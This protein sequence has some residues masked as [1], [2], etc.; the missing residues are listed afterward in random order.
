MKTKYLVRKRQLG[1]VLWIE[2]II[3]KLAVKYKKI[4]VYTKFLELF[5]NY[6]V[7]NVV[8]KKDLNLAE[9]IFCK[10]EYYL[11]TKLLFIN[12][13]GAYE[14]KPK[15]HFLHAYQR[16]TG[17]S[18]TNEYPRLYLSEKEKNI[19]LIKAPKY[20]VLH[21][22]SFANRN[23]RKVYG[24]NW[25]EI[26]AYLKT[27]GFEVV[28]IGQSPENIEGTINAKT[29]IREMINIIQHCSFFIG[30]DSGPSHI[31]ASLQKPSLIFF[32]AVKPEYRHFENLSKV[33]FAQ[34]YCEF[35]GCYH[36]T[37]STKGPL[38]KLVANTEIPKCS[39]HSNKYVIEKIDLL[40]N[41]YL[42]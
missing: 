24:I 2:P 11:N 39:F 1:D 16:K 9:K 40:L 33:I 35:G 41:Q 20:V 13:E 38:C 3:R 17:L 36:D 15:T 5:E 34:Q 18:E 8:F 42:N 29:T 28:Q 22:E 27:K 26:T 30:I 25:N 21:L 32:G 23:Y 7:N 37:I 14:K 10:I 12:L 31:A 19:P 4:I 6:P